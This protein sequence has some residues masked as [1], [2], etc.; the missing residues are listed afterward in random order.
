[1]KF[2]DFWATSMRHILNYIPLPIVYHGC[3]GNP[4]F[5]WCYRLKSE[6]MSYLEHFSMYQ[7]QNWYID[8]IWDVESIKVRYCHILN[9][10]QYIKPKIGTRIIFGM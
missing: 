10:F 6:I 3:H 5:A 9:N 1:M 8:H 2:G 7:A 4:I